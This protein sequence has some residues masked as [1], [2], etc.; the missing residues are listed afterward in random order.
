MWISPRSQACGHLTAA[1]V[2][3][4]RV[5]ANRRPGRPGPPCA[6]LSL[7]PGGT[8]GLAPMALCRSSRC[9]GRPGSPGPDSRWKRGEL[10]QGLRLGTARVCLR[11]G[12]PEPLPVSEYKPASLGSFS[13]CTLSAGPSVRLRRDLH[14]PCVRVRARVCAESLPGPVCCSSLQALRCT[15]SG[16]L[17]LTGSSCVGRACAESYYSLVS[18]FLLLPQPHLLATCGQLRAVC[19]VMEAASRLCLTFL[20]KCHLSCEPPPGGVTDPRGL[21]GC[22]L[23]AGQEGAGCAAVGCGSAF[24]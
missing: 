15:V 9:W 7:A 13:C 21:S 10:C 20:L 4:E 5:L 2:L 16:F 23:A 19:S 24:R 12:T 6:A 22:S 11:L 18:V 14:A 3:A 1:L 8:V 17:F